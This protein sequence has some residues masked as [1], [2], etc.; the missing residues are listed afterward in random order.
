MYI[1]H[2]S[3]GHSIQGNS[4]SG[5]SYINES[6][7]VSFSDEASYSSDSD[8]QQVDNKIRHNSKAIF[9]GGTK[10]SFTKKIH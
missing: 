6:N 1:R 7:Q 10:P 5:P 8:V 9:I 2:L 4:G 3:E